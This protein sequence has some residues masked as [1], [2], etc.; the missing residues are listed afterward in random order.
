MLPEWIHD[1]DCRECPGNGRVSGKYSIF[2]QPEHR[3]EIAPLRQEGLGSCKDLS[4]FVEALCDV[5]RDILVQELRSERIDDF[6]ELPVVEPYALS[7]DSF[8]RTS[9][10]S[11]KQ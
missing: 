9:S 11:G 3:R 2:K 4:C 6:L 1:L 8:P 10:L 5:V 7:L